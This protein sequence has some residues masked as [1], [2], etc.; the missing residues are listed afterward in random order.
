MQNETTIKSVNLSNQPDASVNDT[1]K[2]VLTIAGSSVS[3]VVEDSSVSSETVSA[4]TQDVHPTDTAFSET[5]KAAY[6]VGRG[7]TS[8]IVTV[9][10]AP[11]Q[12][13]I[14]TEKSV[15]SKK[16]RKVKPPAPPRVARIIST[17]KGSQQDGVDHINIGLAAF[18]LLGKQLGED[19]PEMFVVGEHGPFNTITGFWHWL[20]SVDRP[21]DFRDKTGYDV[22][23]KLVHRFSVRSHVENFKVEIMKAHWA[24]INTVVGLR[25]LIAECELPFESYYF[26]GPEPRVCAIAELNSSWMIPVVN[27][28]RRAIRKNIEPNFNIVAERP[29]YNPREEQAKATWE[30]AGIDRVRQAL[31]RQH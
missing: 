17:P 19:W 4:Q 5:P 13:S 29:R 1:D 8:S 3:V 30:K 26:Y 10:E 11:F 23:N 6:K 12:P 31:T 2:D 20:R 21:N 9:D 14:H 22:R 27:E 15:P 7:L 28:F 24:K 25:D 18:T 16:E